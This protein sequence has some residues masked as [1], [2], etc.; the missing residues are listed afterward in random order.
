[1]PLALRAIGG[2][3]AASLTSTLAIAAGAA[4]AGAAAV[5]F[6]RTWQVELPGTTFLESSPLP[7]DLAARRPV[8]AARLAGTGQ[9]RTPSRKAV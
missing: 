4:P 5:G 9:R 7:V 2:L 8:A 6:E 1:M 3:V